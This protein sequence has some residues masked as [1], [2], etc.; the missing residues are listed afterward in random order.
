MRKIVEARGISQETVFSILHEKLGVKKILVRWV[1]RF[2]SEE[3]KRNRVV[4]S[5]A[6]LAFFRGNR[7]EYLRRYISV[8]ETRIH[9]YTSETKEQSKQ[10]VFEGEHGEIGRQG[11]GHS[12]L[13]CTW[14]YLHRL[15]GKRTNDDWTVL[16]VVIAPAERKNKEK[17]SSFENENY[18]SSR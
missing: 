16:C 13:R 5:E 8:D 10:W 3:N 1:P 6:I 11:D 12:F 15:L 7:N 4:D 18:L 9:H 14:N 2:F 17:T